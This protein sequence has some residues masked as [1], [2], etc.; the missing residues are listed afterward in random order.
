MTALTPDDDRLHPA[1]SDHPWW[2]ET[3]WYSFDQPGEDLSATFYP[4]FRRNLGICSL[5]VSLWDPT[6]HEPWRVPYSRSFWH[7]PLPATD[8]TELRLQGLAYDCLEPLQRYHVGYH[9]DGLG[10]IE[11]EFTGLRP[12]HESGIAN[13]VGHL[14]QPCRVVGEVVI[15]DRRIP[16]D[17]IGM[18]DRTWSLRPEDRRSPGTAYTYGHSGA[19][20]QFLVMTTLRG[21]VGSFVS[22]V[23]SGYLVRDGVHAALVDSARRVIERRD[24]YPTRIEVEATD[25]LG[26]RLDAVGVACNRFA[27]QATASQFAWMSMMRWTVVD[28]DRTAT[29][30]IGEDQEVW[31]ADRLGAVLAALTTN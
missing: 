15:R 2:S 19:D 7:L 9:D 26:R 3:C 1:A 5:G 25:A 10:D 13:G 18:R 22:G 17:T 29:D 11:L 24:G 8:L 16:I 6:A 27:N 23:F 21:N 14:D 12:P 4:V 31:S 28:G 20:E 30:V